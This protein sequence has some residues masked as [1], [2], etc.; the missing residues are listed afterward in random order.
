MI[1]C[2]LNVEADIRFTRRLDR[3]VQERGRSLNSVIDQ[4]YS[5]VRPMY[6]KFLAPQVQYADFIVGE[7]TD[8][9]A[10]ILSSKLNI[11]SITL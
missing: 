8:I 5:T 2:F 7:E 1:K 6:Q 11:L 10:S 4:Y 9:A 3:D